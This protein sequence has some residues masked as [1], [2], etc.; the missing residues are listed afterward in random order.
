MALFGR[1]KQE[2]RGVVPPAPPSSRPQPA[3]PPPSNPANPSPAGASA[4]GGWSDIKAVRAEWPQDNLNEASDLASW[5]EGVRLYDNDDYASM[6]R[7][8]SL[9]SPALAHSLYGEGILRGSDLPAT[10]HKIFYA[11]L[12]APPDGRTFAESAQ[13][14]ARLALTITRENGWQPARMGG[15]GLF[16]P[17]I[18]DKGNYMLL[19]AAIAPSGQPWLGDLNQFFAV[20]PTPLADAKVT[21]QGDE[22]ANRMYETLQQANAGDEMSEAHLR[23]MGLWANGQR[24]EALQ[25]L[26]EAARLGSAHAMKDAGDLAQELGRDGEARFWFESAA[27]AGSPGAM[28]NMGVFA[29]NEGDMRIA[30]S[31][32][33]RA[34]EAGAPDG[35][36][37][38]TQLADNMGDAA[39]ERHWAR[40]GAEAGHPF[41]MG[42]HGLYLLMDSPEGDVPAARRAVV[43]LDAAAEAGNMDAMLLT[44]NVHHQLGQFEESSKWAARARATGDPRAIEMLDKY[45]Y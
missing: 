35:Y 9:L 31:W 14:A 17:L 33:Q 4:P 41:C 20:P 43:F 2:S 5:R 13:K 8:A 30:A 18:T 37:A 11:S 1:K 42:R 39:G 27:N 15:Q 29:F 25:A 10:V 6:M 28:F 23:G 44:V 3:N 34:A 22:V 26:S 32:Y 38:L 16:D 19:C 7:C 21:T 45:G 24:E 40:L 12:T 36:A